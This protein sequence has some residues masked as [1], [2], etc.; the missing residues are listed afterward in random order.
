MP[1]IDGSVKAP[2][3]AHFP[4]AGGGMTRL[5]YKRAVEGDLDVKPLLKKAG[6]TL[7]QIDNPNLRLNVTSQITFLNLVAKGMDDETL[8]LNLALNFDL[9]EIGTL[10]YVMASSDTLGDALQRASRYSRITNEAVHLEYRTNK[11]VTIRF[12]YVNV[13][14]HHDRHQIEFFMISLV[15]LVRH[16]SGR[17]LLPT[18]VSFV[19]R[20][21]FFQ[22]TFEKLFGCDV[23]FG[24]NIDEI[25]FPSAIQD[26]PLASADSFLHGL[27]IAQCEKA[28][29]D[30]PRL[31]ALRVSV[32]NEIAPLLPHGNAQAADVA[33]RLGMSQRTLARHLASEGLSF[34]TILDETKCDLATHYL[35]QAD[36]PITTIAWLLG[37]Q[38]VSAFTHAF[39]RWTGTT[40]R[41]ARQKGNW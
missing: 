18:R 13:A 7:Q 40:P 30:R 3:P 33:H 11:E 25:V 19:H 26:I 16:L 20:R 28:N 38:E 4:T 32:E 17:N 2:R 29:I 9:R 23:V 12:E 10:Y 37:Y 22:S 36:L 35:S 27:L 34:T 5:A 1:N 41:Q 21:N 24:R 39:K 8:G 6:L 31:A 15:R 14:R